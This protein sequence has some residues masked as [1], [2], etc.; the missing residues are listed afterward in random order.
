LPNGNSAPGPKFDY[1]LR[2]FKRFSAHANRLL[3][4][5]KPVVLTGDFNVMPTELDVYAPGRWVDDA[6]F[7]PEVREAYRRVVSQGWTDALR[8]LH[9]NERMYTFWHYWR[10]SFA[11]DAGLRIDHFCSALR[12]PRISRKPVSIEQSELV[13]ALVITRQCGLS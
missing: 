3:A 8:K 7:R 4:S 5:G 10:N 9:P 2:W 11:R 13:P 6:L 1:K 12:W